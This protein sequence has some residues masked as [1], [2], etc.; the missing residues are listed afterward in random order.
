MRTK[1]NKTS[2]PKTCSYKMNKQTSQL[3]WSLL[4]I[5]SGKVLDIGSG[6]GGFGIEKPPNVSLFGIERDASIIDQS[7]NYDEI[8][9]EN[10]DENFLMPYDEKSFNGVLARD[11]LEHIEKPWLLLDEVFRI[12]KDGGVFICSVPKPDPKIV[13]N[14]YTHIRGFTKNALSSMVSNAGFKIESLHPLSGFTV[15]TK[16]GVVKYLPIIAKLPFINR[17]MVSFHCVARKP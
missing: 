9:H 6:R 8:I 3:Y 11:I 17:M 4:G 15:A 2:F 10:I 14:D 7:N 12:L 5:V 16:L 13:W 1:N